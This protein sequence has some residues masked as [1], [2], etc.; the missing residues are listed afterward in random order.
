MQVAIERVVWTEVQTLVLRKR[1]D[2]GAPQEL[3]VA[4]EG[5]LGAARGK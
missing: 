4:A 3:P 1:D 2:C 5:A